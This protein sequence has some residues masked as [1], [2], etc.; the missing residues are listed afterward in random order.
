MSGGVETAKLPSVKYRIET[1]EVPEHGG[2]AQPNSQ[3][4][5]LK[6]R[7]IVQVLGHKGGQLRVLTEETE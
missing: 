6:G 7:R 1:I 2:I 5:E 4:R 3:S